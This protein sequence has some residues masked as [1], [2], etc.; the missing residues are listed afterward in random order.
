MS[1]S[2]LDAVVGKLGWVV[3]KRIGTGDCFEPLSKTP[4]WLNTEPNSTP[5]ATSVSLR[6]G[7]AFLDNFLDDAEPFWAGG[8][9]GVLKSVIWREDGIG[10]GQ[11]AIQAQAIATGGN[12][13][14]VLVPQDPNADDI[15]QL[16]QIARTN[17]LDHE[18][19]AREIESKEVLAHC[20]VHDLANPLSA[21]YFAV[22]MLGSSL[23]NPAE[24]QVQKMAMEALRNQRAL[25]QEILDVFSIDS[26]G[27]AA[28]VIDPARLPDIYEI[29]S[30][31]VRF[32][33]LSSNLY[34][35]MIRASALQ[36][37]NGWCVLAETT[38]LERIFG[39]LI[40]NA[41]R[42]SPPNSEVIVSIREVGSFAEVRI[43]DQG[44]GV[45]PEAV[46]HLF[47]K[48]A[49]VRTGKRG[50]AGL[51]LYFCRI[52]VEKWG[53]E[54]GYVNEGADRYFWFR[55]PLEVQ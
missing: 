45:P 9:D 8:S 24:R 4:D 20:I 23:T 21:A 38:R 53:G 5:Q 48:L 2:D 34:N 18:L 39:N 30:K 7:S 11:I 33:L 15:R 13:Y 55:I 37:I 29:A 42:H 50:K 54:I 16:L 47:K 51:G 1:N 10:D 22:E 41:V 6:P 35:V 46:P 26:S 27:Q 52:T 28:G 43:I 32:Q 31:V 3:F 17:Q 49:P 12:A 14:L 19:L 25:I 40:D 36:R 44:H